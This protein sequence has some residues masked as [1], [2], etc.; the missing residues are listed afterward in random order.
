MNETKKVLIS[1]DEEVWREKILGGILTDAGYTVRTA[2][3]IEETLGLLEREY[4]HVV[5]ADICFSMSDH[6]NQDGVR[7][8]GMVAA[9]DEGTSAIVLTGFGTVEL[10]VEALREQKVH[11]FLEKG[12]RFDQE[13]FPDLVETA[14]RAAN[15][16]RIHRQGELPIDRILGEKDLVDTLAKLQVK[17][18]DFQWVL[19]N[20][21]NRV[22]P[23]ILGKSSTVA[24]TGLYVFELKLWSRM[25][26]RDVRF[27]VGSPDAIEQLVELPDEVL[28][29]TDM[30]SAKGIVF[31]DNVPF[32]VY[33][34]QSE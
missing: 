23:V 20:L 10:V 24:G 17:K 21:L 6:T 9:L 4:F 13:A 31:S 15:V 28:F 14:Y 25:L 2:S 5:L 30:H 3:T 7:T 26:G 34:E 32:D 8:I 16:A 1:D 19:K 33:R 11:H 18:P 22:R 12:E 29:R 27:C